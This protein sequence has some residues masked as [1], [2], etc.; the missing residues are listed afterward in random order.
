MPHEKTNN[1]MTLLYNAQWEILSVFIFTFLYIWKEV[2]GDFFLYFQGYA[3]FVHF[4]VSRN[5]HMKR[6]A[7]KRLYY[8]M[9]S[10]RNDYFLFKLNSW[11]HTY[12]KFLQS[13]IK[14]IGDKMSTQL[15]IFFFNCRP[16]LRFRPVL[17]PMCHFLRTIFATISQCA[18]K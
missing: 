13:E 12:F 14:F 7:M 15:L 8:T 9:H 6:R 16:M 11:F 3:G 10:G 18:I 5:C 2:M 1:E 17:K 4:H